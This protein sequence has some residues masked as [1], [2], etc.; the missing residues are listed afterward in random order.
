MSVRECMVYNYK[1][2]MN[3]SSNGGNIIIQSGSPGV[4]CS[5]PTIPDMHDPIIITSEGKVRLKT[6][7]DKSIDVIREIND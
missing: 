7:Y 5:P 2:L 1:D 4:S 6:R 3:C